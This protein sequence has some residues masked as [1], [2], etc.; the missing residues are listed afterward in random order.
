[1]FTACNVGGERYIDPDLSIVHLLG[2]QSMNGWSLYLRVYDASV[3]IGKEVAKCCG[4][5]HNRKVLSQSR[6]LM[7]KTFSPRVSGHLLIDHKDVLSIKLYHT[8]QLIYYCL[9]IDSYCSFRFLINT[10]IINFI[11]ILRHIESKN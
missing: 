2:S 6:N 3:V 9:S 5:E 11:L 7:I 1:M 8:S 10:S 4:R